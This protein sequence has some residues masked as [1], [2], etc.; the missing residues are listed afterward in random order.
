MIRKVGNKY[1]VYNKNHKILIITTY[2]RVAENTDRKSNGK[3]SNRK[4]AKVS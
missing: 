4:T 3:K 2:K 1:L